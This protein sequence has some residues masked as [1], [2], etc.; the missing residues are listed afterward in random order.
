MKDVVLGIL[1]DLYEGDCFNILK[2]SFSF[3]FY[4]EFL[5]IVNKKIV[6]EVKI[7]VKNMVVVGGIVINVCNVYGVLFWCWN[8]LLNFIFLK[9]EFKILRIIN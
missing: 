1:S 9:D 4:K 2:F 3:F 5:V 6:R 7:Y 8:S